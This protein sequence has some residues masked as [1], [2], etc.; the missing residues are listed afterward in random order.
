MAIASERG[1]ATNSDR[2]LLA[3]VSMD[4]RNTFVK[5]FSRRVNLQRFSRSFGDVLS[6]TGLG[7]ERAAEYSA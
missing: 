5:S 4:R 2:P 7:S 6:L 1:S 3:A